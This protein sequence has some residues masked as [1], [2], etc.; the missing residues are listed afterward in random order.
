LTLIQQKTLFEEAFMLWKQNAPQLD[1]ITL[2]AI[3]L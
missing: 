1:D 2:L 3:K